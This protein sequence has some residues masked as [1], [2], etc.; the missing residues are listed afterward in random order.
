MSGM[1]T[2]TTR[3]GDYSS[4]TSGEITVSGL[5]WN[6]CEYLHW[7]ESRSVIWAWCSQRNLVKWHIITFM[8]VRVSMYLC[9]ACCNFIFHKNEIFW[10]ILRWPKCFE[11]LGLM[12]VYRSY[13][14]TAGLCMV[15]KVARVGSYWR[16]T[17]RKGEEI[18]ISKS[19]PHKSTKST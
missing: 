1:T 6:C 9:R 11:Q 15:G 7:K 8:I 3:S 10:E 17:K 5:L 16:R 4:I 2:P 12:F 13:I 18:Q 19:L 14:L